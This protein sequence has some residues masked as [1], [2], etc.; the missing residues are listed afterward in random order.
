MLKPV[1]TLA[2][3]GVLGIVL[4]KLLLLPLASVFLGAL[5]TV[6]KV[7]AIAGLLCILFWRLRRIARSEPKAG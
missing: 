2:G 1:V 3:M 5:F 4:W 6:L 7:A